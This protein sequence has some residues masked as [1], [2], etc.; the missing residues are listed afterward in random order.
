MFPMQGPLVGVIRVI[1]IDDT[2]GAE[3]RRDG[4]SVWCMRGYWLSG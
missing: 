1:I 4:R 2:V 3:A